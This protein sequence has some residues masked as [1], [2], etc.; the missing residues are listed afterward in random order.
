MKQKEQGVKFLKML[1][2][3]GLTIFLAWAFGYIPFSVFL[4]YGQGPAL[5]VILLLVILWFI[6]RRLTHRRYRGTER[7][8]WQR[9]VGGQND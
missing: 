8:L 1:T 7:R 9:P 5:V 2:Y 3:L 6:L 4:L